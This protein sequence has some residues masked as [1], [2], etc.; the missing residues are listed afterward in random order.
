MTHLVRDFESSASSHIE[1][2]PR[3]WKGLAWEEGGGRCKARSARDHLLAFLIGTVARNL[4]AHC[5]VKMNYPPLG[6]IRYLLQHRTNPAMPY[7]H[8]LHCDA[9]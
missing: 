2:S 8:K 3:A 4:P 5:T 9:A 6:P 7:R 1:L